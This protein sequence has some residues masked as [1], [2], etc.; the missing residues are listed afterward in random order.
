MLDL[1]MHPFGE[2][3]LAIFEMLQG[4]SVLL[5]LTALSCVF[6]QKDHERPAGPLGGQTAEPSRLSP[7][8]MSTQP[9]WT[10]SWVGDLLRTWHTTD[11]QC[12]SLCCVLPNG[13]SSNTDQVEFS[14][15]ETQL[16]YDRLTESLQATLVR[17]C[18]EAGGSAVASC[19]GRSVEA[20][21]VLQSGYSLWYSNRPCDF[22]AARGKP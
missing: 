5:V 21:N 18:L 19:H 10:T 4:L 17:T 2:P 12:G 6:A 22:N 8:F 14:A 20:G 7:I 16:Q 15:S 11:P 13:V 1:E 3:S 9:D